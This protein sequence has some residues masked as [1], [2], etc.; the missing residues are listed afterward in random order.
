MCSQNSELFLESNSFLKVSGKH[1]STGCEPFLITAAVL[2]VLRSELRP[3][4][5]QWSCLPFSVDSIE[6][7]FTA[8]HLTLSAALNLFTARARLSNLTSALQYT[9]YFFSTGEQKILLDY[10]QLS[11][12]EVCH[13]RLKLTRMTVVFIELLHLIISRNRDL[14]LDL[15]SDDDE[16]DCVDNDSDD[17]NNEHECEHKSSSSNDSNISSNH[18]FDESDSIV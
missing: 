5:D 9:I 14:L 13:F 7:G 17:D 11:E 4:T 16:Q 8:V 10:D 12:D 3:R 2:T 15:D 1:F 6:S 18:L